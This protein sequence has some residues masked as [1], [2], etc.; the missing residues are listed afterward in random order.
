MAVEPPNPV[1]TSE[2]PDIPSNK[3][4]QKF[5]LGVVLIA[6]LIVGLLVGMLAL[7]KDDT[8]EENASTATSEQTLK[9]GEASLYVEDIDAAQLE[10]GKV[11]KV[12]IYEDSG[13]E[14]VN[15]VQVAVKYPSDK[16]TFKSLEPGSAFPVQA[17]TDTATP[18]LIRFAQNVQ[19][20]SKTAKGKQLIAN[21][22]FTVTG[23]AS[24]GDVTIDREFS[25]VVRSTDNKNILNADIT[26]E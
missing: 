23:K 8:E 13:E 9:A 24:P 15:A 26:A 20:N 2:K 11:V 21:V 16:L 7:Q 12:G 3:G 1:P 18:G 19:D 14:T 17:V 25:L 22:E 5:Y 6:L 4:R 10:A